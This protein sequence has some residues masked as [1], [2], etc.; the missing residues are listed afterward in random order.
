MATSFKNTV[1]NAI[2]TTPVQVVT[3]TSLTRCT[4]I[5]LSLANITGGNVSVNVMVM[6]DTSTTGYY[7]KGV[8][9]PPNSSLRVVNQGEKLILAPSNQL[10]VQSNTANSIDCIVSYVEIN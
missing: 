5:G 9:I 2:G 6:D 8:I 4:V 10:L 3:T 1:E 7:V